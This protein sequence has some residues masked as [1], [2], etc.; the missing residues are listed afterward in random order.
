MIQHHVRLRRCASA[1]GVA[2][3]GMAAASSFAEETAA[4]ATQVVVVTAQSRNQQIQNVPIAVQSLSGDALKDIG[5]SNLGDIDAFVPGLSIDASQATRPSIFLRGVGTQDF[6]I[7]TDSPV[8]VYADGVYAG[9]TGGSMLNFND[10]KRIEV[11]KGPQGTLFGRNA[12][13]GAISIVTNEPGDEKEASVLVRAG[14]MGMHHEE[15]LYNTPISD[16]LALRF[17]AIDQ[18]DDGWAHNAYNGT[19]M[20]NDGDLGTR[21][22]LRWHNA[23]TSAIVSW[24]H[25]VMRASGPPVLSVTDGKIDFGSPATWSNPL[26]QQLVNDASPDFQS[27]TFDGVSLRVETPLPFATLTSTTAYR[28]F[29]S[30]NWQDNDASANPVTYLAT[31]NLESNSTWQ[32]EFKLSGQSDRLD[33]VSGVSAY[34][35]RATETENVDATT[36]SLDTI[37]GHAAGVAPYATLTQ[38]AQGVGKATG[39]AALQGL[40]LMGLPWQEGISNLGEYRAY[41]AYGD[42]IWHA[43]SDTNLTIGGRYTH[44]EKSFSWYNPPRTAAALD[45]SLAALQQAKF[46][47]TLVGLKLLTAQQSALLQGV[48][49]SNIEF[50][51]PGSSAAPFAVSDSWNNF[52]PRVVLD[53]HLS[54][55]HMAYVSWSKGYQAGGFDAVNVNGHYDE[56]KVT[57]VEVGMKGQLRGIGVSYGVSVFHYDYTNLQSLTL[58]PASA[59]SGIPSYQVVNSDQRATGA[60]L[61]AQWKI[62]RVWRLSGSAEYIDQTYAHYLSPTGVNLDGQPAGAP[63][64]SASAGVT[65]KWPAWDGKADFNL[66]YGYIG[67]KRCN[68][69]TSTQGTCLETGEVGAGAAQQH[70]DMRL[71]WSAPSGRWST[72]LVVTNL[73][74]KQYIS[75]ST[76]GQAVGSPYAYVSKPRMIALELRVQL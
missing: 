37:L 23:D 21:A 40:S 43:T 65:A 58:V 2:L 74:D 54:P 63:Y 16:S 35:E 1:V 34:R 57:N 55:D 44:D 73:L 30:Q 75:I 59:T 46:F 18:R 22:A 56:E 9:K 61:D 20:G 29:N 26:K 76:L 13:A 5:V 42:A 8:G 27:R 36:T 4:D 70:L 3:A 47:P 41:A 14:L 62:N 49:A 50:T 32:Q 24:E 67:H 33:W 53:R 11:L 25:E 19:R 68:A 52:S 48:V 15:V 71:G 45:A 66:M 12:A 72:G 60:D 10:V 31:G 64:L 7:G 17:S 69:D 38:L 39:N 51:N 6:G 28:H